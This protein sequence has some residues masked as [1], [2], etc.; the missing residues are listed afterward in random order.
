MVADC[1]DPFLLKNS[2]NVKMMLESGT[3]EEELWE[4]AQNAAEADYRAETLAR[5][6]DGAGVYALERKPGSCFRCGESGHKANECSNRTRGN[7]MTCAACGNQGH[8]AQDCMRRPQNNQKTGITCYACGETGHYANECKSERKGMPATIGERPGHLRRSTPEL[9]LA[10]LEARMTTHEQKTDKIMACLENLC[11]TLGEGRGQGGQ[12][13]PY[14]EHLSILQRPDLPAGNS[15]SP[16][17]Q[18]N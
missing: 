8:T 9:T 10:T 6:F 11:K 12:N 2:N 7:N 16:D 13:A 17:I 4:M 5:C 1:K 15:A 3:S 14:N 18:K